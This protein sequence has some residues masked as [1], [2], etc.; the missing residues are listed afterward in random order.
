[1]NT[2]LCVCGDRISTLAKQLRRELTDID[3]VFKDC[4][5][6]VSQCQLMM[7]RAFRSH[8]GECQEC[9]EHME[10]MSAQPAKKLAFSPGVE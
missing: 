10:A 8:V 5:V 7:E 9:R 3:E 1:M 2:G 4:D 6:A